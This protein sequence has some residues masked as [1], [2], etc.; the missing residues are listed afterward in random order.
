MRDA[1][2]FDSFN[3]DPVQDYVIR[4]TPVVRTDPIRRF[5]KRFARFLSFGTFE[6]VADHVAEGIDVD[7]ELTQ[8]YHRRIGNPEIQTFE[9]AVIFIRHHYWRQS[10]HLI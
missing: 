3:F 9:L 5:A 8:M 2:I 7:V 10:T 4:F 1:P 6:R